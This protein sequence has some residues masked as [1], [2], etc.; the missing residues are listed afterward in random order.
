MSHYDLSSLPVQDDDFTY[1]ENI[2]AGYL[3]L[4]KTLGASTSCWAADTSLHIQNPRAKAALPR[5][6]ITAASSPTYM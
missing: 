4:N 6:T 3:V 1:T 5:Q 2:Y